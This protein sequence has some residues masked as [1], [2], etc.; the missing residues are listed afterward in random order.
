[1]HCAEPLVSSINKEG[2]ARASFYLYNTE[3]E[4]QFFAN[5]LKETLNMFK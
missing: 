5:T 1:M 2:L 3:E 4:I